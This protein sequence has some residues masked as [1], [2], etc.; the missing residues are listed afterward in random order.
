MEI[1]GHSTINLT[2]GTYT[3]V[4]P[5]LAREAVEGIGGALWG[6]KEEEVAIKTAPTDWSSQGTS[7]H[8]RR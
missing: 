1:L 3:H 6:P 2:L 5:E 4:A 7:S 8:L